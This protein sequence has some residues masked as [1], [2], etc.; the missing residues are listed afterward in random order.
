MKNIKKGKK[1]WKY[2]KKMKRKGHGRAAEGK[3]QGR[4]NGSR[5]K[6]KRKGSK[7]SKEIQGKG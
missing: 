7:G 3:K 4:K 2:R 6:I 5:K 1:D